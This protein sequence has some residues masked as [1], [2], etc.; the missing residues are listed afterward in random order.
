MIGRGSPVARL[1]STTDEICCDRAGI[2]LGAN[3]TSVRNA[4]DLHGLGIIS[5]IA[6]DEILSH[7]VIQQDG[8]HGRAN[9]VRTANGGLH[10]GRFGWKADVADLTQFIGEALRNELGITNPLAPMDLVDRPKEKN[11]HCPGD[12]PNPEDDGTI[13]NALTAF[14]ASLPAPGTEKIDHEG[15]S[16]FTRIRCDACHSPNMHLRN[17]RVRLYSD[18]LIHDLGAEL[19]DSFVQGQARGSDWRTAPLWGLR[20]RVRFLHD[21]RAQTISEA[22]LLHGGEAATVKRRFEDLTSK[23]RLALMKF[24]SGL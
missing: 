13:L 7:A 21:G 5:A 18:L 16:I 22:I 6:D 8:I 3:L 11:H 19:D 10:V 1:H 9:W 2:P 20:A 12:N 23:D 14:V 17:R 15:A 4:P 24:L